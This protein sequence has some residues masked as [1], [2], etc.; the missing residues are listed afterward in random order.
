MQNKTIGAHLYS[1]HQQHGLG[2]ILVCFKDEVRQL[3]ND[4]VQWTLVL[5]GLAKV[6][7]RREKKDHGSKIKVLTRLA[8]TLKLVHMTMLK[9]GLI[10]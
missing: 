5:Q 4:D 9:I 7:L 1:L 2:V 3:V 6:Q 8:C 10:L